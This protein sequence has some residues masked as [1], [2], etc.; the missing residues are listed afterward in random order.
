M[1]DGS[2]IFFWH[3]RWCDGV[4]LRDCFPSLF[5]LAAEKDALVYDYLERNST[6][7]VWSP[8]FVREAFPDHDNV[9]Q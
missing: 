8:I 1:G 3:S 6:W 4:H 9:A 5:A 7:V 2:S